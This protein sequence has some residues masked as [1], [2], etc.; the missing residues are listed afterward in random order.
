MWTVKDGTGPAS[1]E[2]IAVFRLVCRIHLEK[3]ALTGSESTAS[4]STF[5]NFGTQ[6]V[7]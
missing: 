2:Q 7:P 6:S 5:D 3:T 1:G 4:G